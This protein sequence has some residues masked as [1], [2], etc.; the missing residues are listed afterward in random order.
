MGRRQSRENR[1]WLGQRMGR[2]HQFFLITGV[3]LK[4]RYRPFM[5]LVPSADR[6]K[7]SAGIADK[8]AHQEFLVSSQTMAVVSSTTDFFKTG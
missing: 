3:H 8:S 7:Q 1:V 2:D 6:S 4:F 5:V